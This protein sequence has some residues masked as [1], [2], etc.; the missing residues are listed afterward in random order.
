[1]AR[2]KLPATQLDVDAVRDKFVDTLYGESDRGCV[3]VAAAMMDE[4]LEVLLREH[5][6]S[7]KSSV[8]ACVEPLFIGLG[9]LKS[10]WAK[11][12]LARAL[13]L[14]DEWMYKDL[15]RMR[16]LRNLF[17]H[18]YEQ[19]DFDDPRVIA[20]TNSLVGADKAV[21]SFNT[22]PDAN[23][24]VHPIPPPTSRR[25]VKGRR[26]TSKKE[27]LRFTL[28]ASYIGGRLHGNALGYRDT[29]GRALG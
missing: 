4:G 11:T 13:G 8:N 6:L 22:G 20:L 16:N 2:K 23:G 15:D 18:S 14:I 29:K 26:R 9:P 25:H 1:M 24:D 28:A 10:F 19:A 21:Q 7:D 5:M 17:A 3:L 12:Q 27:R